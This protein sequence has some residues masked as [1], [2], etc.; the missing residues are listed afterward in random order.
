MNDEVKVFDA[1]KARKILERVNNFRS[2]INYELTDEIKI[3]DGHTLHRI[4]AVRDLP[5]QGIKA[6]DLGGWIESVDNLI[7]DAWVHDEA[8]VYGNACVS[9]NACIYDDAR[10]YGDANIYDNVHVFDNARVYDDAYICGDA[11]IFDNASVYGDAYVCNDVCIF[12]N[13]RVSGEVRVYGGAQICGDA[14][15]KS[16]SDYF[17]VKNIWSSFRWFTYTHSNKM[18]KVGC[19]Y[20]TG[21]E[22]IAKAY[23]DSELSGKCYEEVVRAQEAIYKAIE[24]IKEV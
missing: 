24:E 1:L 8:K 4:R 15:V 12:D 3:I 10:V 23:K 19:F 22:L 9:G 6:G 5:H 2:E 18:W 21:E 14:Q 7:G 17:I 16:D 11:R 20:G 13:A